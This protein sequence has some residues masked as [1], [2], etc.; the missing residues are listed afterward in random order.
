VATQKLALFA[1]RVV[2]NRNDDPVPV[3][4][5]AAEGDAPRAA[6]SPKASRSDLQ[7]LLDRPSLATAQRSGTRCSPSWARVGRGLDWPTQFM[8]DSELNWLHHEAPV[9]DL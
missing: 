7:T 9:D 8:V 1:C 2:L 3:P 4:Q 5:V 6:A